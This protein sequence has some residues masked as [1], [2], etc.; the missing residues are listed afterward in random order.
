MTAI[1]TF[2]AG[3]LGTALGFAIVLL[4]RRNNR[5]AVALVDAFEGLMGRLPIL[6]VLYGLLLRHLRVV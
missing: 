4:R 3:V 2:G 1:I 6:V 5:V